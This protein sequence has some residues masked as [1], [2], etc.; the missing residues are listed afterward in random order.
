MQFGRLLK[1]YIKIQKLT[2]YQIAKETGIDRSFL[3]GVLNG[4]RKLPQKRFLDIVNG[5]YFTAIQIHNLCEEYFLERFGR[6]KIQ[7]FQFIENGLTGKLKEELDLEYFSNYIKFDKNKTYFSSSK[8]VADAVYSILNKDSID[9]FFS[10][11]E[12]SNTEINRIIFNSCKKRKFKNF[13]HF[14]A[15]DKFSSIRN[16]EI[17]FNSLYYAETGYLTYSG[18][19]YSFNSVMPFF[20]VADDY[21]LVFDEKA[22]NALLFKISEMSNF[23]RIQKAKIESK[24]HKLAFITETPFEFANIL[25]TININP[26][27]EGYDNSLCPT[28]I[29]PEILETI[30]TPYAKNEIPTLIK[31]V[32]THYQSLISTDSESSTIKSLVVTYNAITN[33]LK[34]GVLSGFPKLLANPVPQNMRK[35]FLESLLVKKNVENIYITNPNLFKANKDLNLQFSNNYLVICSSFGDNSLEDYNGKITLFTDNEFVKGAFYDYYKY[36]IMSE[37]TYSKDDSLNIIQSFI[38]RCY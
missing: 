7:Q 24:C 32:T 33:F 10:N 17:I 5:K 8:E 31:W 11:F 22:E 12:F 9:N 29:T 28:F 35:H 4:T 23:F 2:I 3:Q 14:I 6:Q 25:S 15:L 37:K 30:A 20:I 16:I 21:S 38:D 1:E 26:H 18:Y 27:L 34:N 13:F 19:Q 36:M